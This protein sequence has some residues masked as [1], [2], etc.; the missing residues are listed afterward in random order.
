MRSK[1]K[2]TKIKRNFKYPKLKKENYRFGSGVLV[3]TVLR[4]DGDW[5]P[6]LSPEEDQNKWGTESS[7]CYVEAQQ[8]AIATIEEEELGEVDNNYSSRFNALLSNGTPQGGDPIAGA[9]SIRHFGMV[10]ESSM[11]FDEL[12]QSWADFHSWLGVDKEKTLKEGLIYLTSK[13]LNFDVVVERN[14][15]V[16]TKYI[17]LRQALKYS[18]LPTSVYA[19][20]ERDGVYIKPKGTRDNHLTLLVYIDEKNRP[21]FWD[22]YS[23][24]LKIG[25]PWYN[26][27]F[28]MRWSVKK[29]LGKTYSSNWVIDL[30]IS[31]FKGR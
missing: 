13:D 18:P 11:P 25:E 3:G 23:P 2:H 27:D 24:Y 30:F 15:P 5:R 29:K 10:K 26:C 4:E 16:K 14:Q 9:D 31:L 1:I 20:V 21:Y 17:K 12:I 19:W 8:H 28:S 7:A 6:Y 22:T